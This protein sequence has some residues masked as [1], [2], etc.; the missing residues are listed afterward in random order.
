MPD[1][2]ALPLI[3]KSA[4]NPTKFTAKSF[5]HNF[6][7]LS[8][9]FP[10]VR[11][12]PCPRKVNCAGTGTIAYGGGGNFCTAFFPFVESCISMENNAILLFRPPSTLYACPVAFK[13][14]KQQKNCETRTNQSIFRGILQK[15]NFFRFGG[16][17][18]GTEEIAFCPFDLFWFRLLSD[19]ERS[20]KSAKSAVERKNQEKIEL[21]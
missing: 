20:R 1:P 2:R 9:N 18:G 3:Q 10:F 19:D 11:F 12:F 5:L 14:S 6:R 8:Q 17:G 21:G 7:P 13:E 4:H 15:K 16:G